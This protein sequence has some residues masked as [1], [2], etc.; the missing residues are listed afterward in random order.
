MGMYSASLIYLMLRYT[1]DDVL[2]A[3][4]AV[5]AG[6]PLPE[7]DY[8]DVCAI[9]TPEHHSGDAFFNV[10]DRMDVFVL[11][12]ALGW[13]VKAVIVR[14]VWISWICSVLFEFMELGFAHLLANF[15]ECWWDSIIL[16]VLGCNLI[17]IYSAHLFMK[18]FKW[19]QYNFIR[20]CLEPS[21]SSKNHRSYQ[22]LFCSLLLIILITLIDLNVFFIKF[23]LFLP[24]THWLC[25]LRTFMWVL[26]SAPASR[27]LAVA[28]ANSPR[29]SLSP[30]S[31]SPKNK[32]FVFLFF[33]KVPISC[34][35]G[36]VGLLTEIIACIRFKGNLFA[37]APH[38]PITTVILIVSLLYATLWSLVHTHRQTNTH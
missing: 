16:D 24:T 28:A 30:R 31:P 8:G 2:S 19:K 13:F 4:H 33:Q 6:F 12:H 11:A 3:L 1:R 29:K 35:L 14:D 18:T 34:V 23:I 26:I 20:K 7:K 10:R 17:G 27:E 32:R 37:N 22:Y 38:T 15:N 25:L 21:S 36:I 9:Y 5:G